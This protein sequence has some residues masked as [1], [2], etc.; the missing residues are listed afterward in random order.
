MARDATAEE[1]VDFFAE[2]AA[3]AARQAVRRVL[4]HVAAGQPEMSYF[5]FAMSWDE[6]LAIDRDRGGTV[7]QEAT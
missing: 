3:A 2:Q 7:W 1:I 5:Q 6:A 4:V